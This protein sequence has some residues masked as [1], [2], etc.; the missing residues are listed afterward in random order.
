MNWVKRH[1]EPQSD[2]GTKGP[3]L[4]LGIQVADSGK[5]IQ[6]QQEQKRLRL[7]HVSQAARGTC[8]FCAIAK[9][10]V[11]LASMDSEPGELEER[12]AVAGRT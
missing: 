5:H 6:A 9:R 2:N 4:L 1:S 10:R 7:S 12:L 8:C 3:C 11:F